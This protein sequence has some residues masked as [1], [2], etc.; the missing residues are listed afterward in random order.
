M[1][2][3]GCMKASTVVSHGKIPIQSSMIEVT[4][5]EGDILCNGRNSMLLCCFLEKKNL[6]KEESGV[7][8]SLRII[9]YEN[10]VR[11]SCVVFTAEACP[12]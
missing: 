8:R 2:F 3:V 4:L 5:M 12:L 9:W 11:N 10:H 1:A 7:V 6:T